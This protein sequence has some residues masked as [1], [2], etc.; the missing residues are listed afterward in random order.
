MRI[1]VASGKG[2]TGK[3]LLATSLARIW[4]DDGLEVEYI[5][6]DVEEPNGHLFLKPQQVASRRISVPVPALKG[7]S[8][9]G[10]GKCQEACAFHAILSLGDS[11]MVFNELCHGC[12]ACSISCPDGA[13]LEKQR[14]IGTIRHGFSLAMR[15]RE[16]LLD[17]G[18]ARSAP[19]IEE[20]V[21]GSGGDGRL[22]VIDCPP[23]TA[24]SAVAAVEGAD[25]LLLVTEPT[26][27]GLHDLL[28][29]VEM[30]RALNLPMAAVVNRADLGSRA[31]WHA[32]EKEKIPVLAG[33]P[34]RREIAEAY[35]ASRMTVEESPEFR[36]MVAALGDSLL[37]NAGGEP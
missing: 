28:L 34:F 19:L 22:A 23:G 25:L 20:V 27:F 37:D 35:S 32:L 17:V 7:E 12:G 29:A 18:E 8:C 21:R 3:T 36:G 13:L 15:F 14:E 6:A 10:H 30:G 9:S 4:S 33:I 1:A 31:V 11:V 5:D 26:P 16:G 24:C 2:G